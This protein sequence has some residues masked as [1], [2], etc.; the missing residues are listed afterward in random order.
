MVEAG[1]HGQAGLTHKTMYT[2][3]PSDGAGRA[4][5]AKQ[6]PCSQVGL[7]KEGGGLRMGDVMWE[8]AANRS[9]SMYPDRPGSAPAPYCTFTWMRGVDADGGLHHRPPGRHCSSCEPSR[10]GRSAPGCHPRPCPPVTAASPASAAVRPSPSV[11]TTN[12]NILFPASSP[13]A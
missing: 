7:T 11:C 2:L 12:T 13:L 9:A 4:L 8:E 10:R 1:P 5:A 3:W 6:R